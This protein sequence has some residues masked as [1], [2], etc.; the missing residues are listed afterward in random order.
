MVGISITMARTMI[1]ILQQ[2]SPYH[3]ESGSEGAG[4]VNGKPP[5]ESLASVLA[6]SSTATVIPSR[7]LTL[8]L[9]VCL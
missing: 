5:L 9:R 6:L 3:V 2:I 7:R 4:T 1:Q 8:R